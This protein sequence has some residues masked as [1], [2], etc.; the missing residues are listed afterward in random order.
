MADAELKHLEAQIEHIIKS[1]QRLITENSSLKKR[2]EQIVRE[3]ASHLN[4]TKKIKDLLKQTII[5]LKD[6]LA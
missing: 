3:R 2:L 4:K 5:Q 6:K 1:H